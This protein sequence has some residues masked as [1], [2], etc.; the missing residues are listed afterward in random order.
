MIGL[1]ITGGTLDKDYDPITGALTFPGTCVPAML[2]QARSTLT[3][4]THVLMQK[5]SLDMTDTDRHAIAEACAN[6]PAQRLVITHGTDTMVD[7]AITLAQDARLQAK[8]ILLTGAMRPFRLGKS[9]AL[10]N[11]GAALMAVQLAERGVWIAMN[12]RLLPAT[13]ATKD[14]SR[15]V[16]IGADQP[17]R[18]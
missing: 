1:I 11:L 12:G 5:D 13:T 9:D 15:G 6:H 16:F 3:V 18:S 4:D 10:F 17:E 8:T 2:E 14:R 7:T